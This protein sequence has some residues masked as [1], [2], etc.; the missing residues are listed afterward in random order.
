MAT[1]VQRHKGPVV[2]FEYTTTED[3]G[4]IRCLFNG[5]RADSRLIDLNSQPFNH[6]SLAKED[7]D[8]VTVDI[9]GWLLTPYYINHIHSQREVQSFYSYG[10]ADSH[11]YLLDLNDA[12]AILSH[13]GFDADYKPDFIRRIANAAGDIVLYGYRTRGNRRT[14]RCKFH[15]EVCTHKVFVEK[16]SQFIA[17]YQ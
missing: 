10:W 1:D 16:F 4:P 11:D 7:T 2:W 12:M 13:F 9:G 15:G 3:N 5:N 14:R 6:G 8:Q 17:K